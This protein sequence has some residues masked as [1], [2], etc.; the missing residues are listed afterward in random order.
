MIRFRISRVRSAGLQRDKTITF[1]N[2]KYIYRLSKIFSR[3]IVLRT[4]REDILQMEEKI[5]HRAAVVVDSALLLIINVYTICPFAQENIFIKVDF[6]T[7]RAFTFSTA[8]LLVL[9]AFVLFPRI[10]KDTHT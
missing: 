7:D 9:A 1:F 10:I 8:R 4:A 2:G 3:K 5:N 6:L